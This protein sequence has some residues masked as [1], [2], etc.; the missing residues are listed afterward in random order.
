MAIVSN[1]EVGKRVAEAMGA[2]F[3]AN[4]LEV[5]TSQVVALD[6]I[7]AKIISNGVSD[8]A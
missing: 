4:G 1:P 8:Q 2:A 6:P 7:G 5:N 3:R